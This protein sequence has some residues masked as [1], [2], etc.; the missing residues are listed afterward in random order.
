MIKS[1]HRTIQKRY[2]EK[3]QKNIRDLE[4]RKKE[5]YDRLPQIERI[6]EEIASI[7]LR[8]NKDILLGKEQPGQ[9]QAFYNALEK[10][11]QQKES[12]LE[13]A[14]FDKTYLKVKYH[15]ARCDDTGFLPA[16]V[17][18]GHVKCA[19][20][21]QQIIDSIYERSNLHHLDKQSFENFDLN[22][23]SNEINLS[24]YGV[25]ISPRQHMMRIKEKVDD[26][27]QNFEAFSYRGLLFVG[28]TGTGKTFLS[29]CIAKALMDQGKTVLYLSAP[30]LFQKLKNVRTA[31]FEVMNEE[32]ETLRYIM[33]AE[34]LIIDDLGVENITGSRYAEF[35]NIL[36]ARATNDA[37]LNCKTIISTNMGFKEL[38]DNYTERVVS[39]L[40]GDFLSIKFVGEDLRLAAHKK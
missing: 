19:C 13:G 26:F 12:L 8:Y 25:Q 11:N 9:E 6:D 15:C 30:A 22:R 4:K 34:L 35:L 23:F 2:E 37:K 28:P 17:G 18:I 14:G 16:E 5:V 32:E 36:N 40:V 3:K 1:V 31:K 33:E 29:N 10:L 24:K 38:R 39:R 20:Y 21:L 27:I 7:G